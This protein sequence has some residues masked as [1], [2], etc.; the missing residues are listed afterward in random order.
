MGY[1]SCSHIQELSIPVILQ[2]GHVH[3]HTQLA[4]LAMNGTLA[5][6]SCSTGWELTLDVSTGHKAVCMPAQDKSEVACSTLF[7]L[8]TMST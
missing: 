7:L 4:I 5:L 1:E 8:L 3:A 2:G 6:T